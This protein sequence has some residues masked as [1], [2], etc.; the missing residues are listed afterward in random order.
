MSDEEL[1]KQIA[2]M[3]KDPGKHG[4]NLAVA[5]E[6][7]EARKRLKQRSP[8]DRYENDP[9]YKQLT[10][11]IEAMIHE[12]RFS[13]S[14]VRECAVLACVHHEMRYGFK[15]YTV[16][17]PVKNHLEELASWRSGGNEIL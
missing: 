17:L 3:E 6:L 1:A 15:H 7:R 4:A 5:K 13:P 10:D 11:A 9:A 16:P 2:A 14:E 12:S 8:K